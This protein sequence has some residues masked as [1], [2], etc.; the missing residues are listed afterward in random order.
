MSSLT[1]HMSSKLKSIRAILKLSVSLSIGDFIVFVVSS[2]DFCLLFA[3]LLSLMVYLFYFF[4]SMF[5]FFGVLL[6]LVV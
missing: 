5:A 2:F 3:V 1:T 4:V 6:S